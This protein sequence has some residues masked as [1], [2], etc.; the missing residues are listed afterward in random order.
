VGWLIIFILFVREYL[1]NSFCLATIKSR[2]SILPSPLRSSSVELELDIPN[3]L[4]FSNSRVVVVGAV[5]CSFY[6]SHRP[7]LKLTS[8][9]F[10]Q[11][12]HA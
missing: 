1:P 10:S 12:F 8:L 11:D 3:I 4:F 5:I 6:Q 7:L 9:I 2:L